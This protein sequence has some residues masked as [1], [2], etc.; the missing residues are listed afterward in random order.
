MCFPELLDVPLSVAVHPLP[1]FHASTPTLR[2]QPLGYYY[3]QLKAPGS[4][5]PQGLAHSQG[6]AHAETGQTGVSQNGHISV[7]HVLPERC[8]CPTKSWRNR[9]GLCDYLSTECGESDTV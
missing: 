8:C 9:V 1:N 3:S 7:L 2:R 4:L 6:Q 5:Y